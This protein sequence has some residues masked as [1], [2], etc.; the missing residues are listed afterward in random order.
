MK[1]ENLKV[2]QAS[3]LARIRWPAAESYNPK[4]QNL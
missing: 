3:A 4:T 1:E 2:E